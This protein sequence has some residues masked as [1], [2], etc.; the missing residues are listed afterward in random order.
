MADN[1]TKKGRQDDV[2]IN[3]NQDHEVNYWTKELGITK[4]KLAEAVKA[5]GVMVADVKKYLKK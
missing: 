5:V 2:R 3:L 4:E 1:L